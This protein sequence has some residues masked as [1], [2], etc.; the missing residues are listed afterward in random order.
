LARSQ[1]YGGQ[2]FSTIKYRGKKL[3]LKTLHRRIELNLIENLDTYNSMK[4]PL[5]GIAA[6]KPR[7]VSK[8]RKSVEEAGGEIKT[9]Y[10]ESFTIEALDGLNGLLLTGGGDIDASE[11]DEPNHPQVYNVDPKRDSMELTLTRKALEKNL[12]VLGI[13]RGLQVMNVAMGGNLIQHLEGHDDSNSERY[14]IAHPVKILEG[15]K[16]NRILGKSSA[17][18]NSFHHQAIK[19][20]GDRLIATAWSPDNVIEG[21]EIPDADYFI[22]VQWHPEEFVD[23]GKDFQALFDSLVDAARTFQKK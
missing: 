4:K 3:P 14:N 15:T 8:Y 11:F 1:L 22:G 5:I 18:V 6:D 12:P 13:C 7:R 21:I 23:F 17:G 20:L 19:H 9:L 2:A 10:P 16:L